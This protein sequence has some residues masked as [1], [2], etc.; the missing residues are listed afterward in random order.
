ME[1]EWREATAGGQT[2]RYVDSGTGPLVVL[3]HGFPDLPATW[4]SIRA[5]LNEA[6]FRTVAPY[7]RGYHPATFS[8]RGF[9]ADDLADDVPLLLDALDE[10]TAMVV[11]HD[12]GTALAYG[13]ATKHPDRV[14][15]MVALGVPHPVTIR[16][17][18]SALVMGRHFVWFKLPWASTSARLGGLKVIDRFYRRFSP[19][20]RGEERDAAVAAATEAFR[21]PDVLAG[22]LAYYKALQP[23]AKLLRQR[24]AVPGLVVG[25]AEEPDILQAAYAATPGRFDAPCDV[26]VLGGAGHWPHRENEDAFVEVLL[27]FLQS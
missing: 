19:N 2:F 13:A 18:P 16:Q 24:I 26:H 14:S 9:S 3:F 6:G 12:W 8:M 17:S 10:R 25:G 22:A 4:D 7:L 20:W 5:R 23:G 11:G 15:K 27:P 1:H 21:D